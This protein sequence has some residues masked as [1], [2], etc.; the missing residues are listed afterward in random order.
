[1]PKVNA[2]YNFA[3]LHPELLASWHL[4]RNKGINP[5]ELAPKSNH[6]VWWKCEKG[7]EWK[8]PISSRTNGHGCY[9]CS[10]NKTIGGIKNAALKRSGS[11][12]IKHPELCRQIDNDKN[13]EIDLENISTGSNIELYW[14]C[15][16]GHSWRAS[17]KTR[18]NGHGCPNCTSKSSRLEM[19]LLSELKYL[20]NNVRWRSKI[21]GYE[22][23]ILLADYNLGIEIDGKYWH[24]EKL[25]YD[26]SKNVA[27]EKAGYKLLRVREKGLKIINNSDV[28]FKT[29]EKHLAIFHRVLNELMHILPRHEH[30]N[31]RAL[32]EAG[33]FRNNKLY[34]QLQSSVSKPIEDNSLSKVY[35]EICKDWHSD[36]LPL[37]PDMFYPK[38]HN[39]VYWDCKIH[40]KYLTSIA[41]RVN[42][43]GCPKCAIESRSASTRA[44][45]LNKSGNISSISSLFPDLVKEWH[46]NRNRRLSPES[47][48]HGSKKK[49]WWL[50][51]KCGSE[52]EAQIVNRTKGSNCPRCSTRARG[53]AIAKAALKRSGSLMSKFPEVAKFWDEG[54][55]DIKST[56]VSPSSA[57]EAYWTCSKNHSYV[58][59][60][61]VRVRM[62]NCPICYSN[63]KK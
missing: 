23:D 57:Y 29:N 54:L 52:W 40:G 33:K 26:I 17:V 15:D 6:K 7:H 48:S 37:T 11:L 36:N 3:I 14:K 22:C 27:F 56:Q 32:L 25:E 60:V 2:K 58:R 51:N 5:Y 35:P 19:R 61:C 10:R 28:T 53:S 31:I 50:C 13:G 62:K 12:K 46:P 63:R 9:K 49:V 8:A 20:F 41:H 1:M 4:E 47:F 39:K 21:D 55:N 34:K 24:K 30:S 42:G 16:F 59:K 45:A 38:S 43:R 44:A 18:V